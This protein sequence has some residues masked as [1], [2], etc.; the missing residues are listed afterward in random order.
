MDAAATASASLFSVRGK[1]VLVTGGSRGIGL[2]IARRMVAHGADVLLSSRDAAACEAAARDVTAESST[3]SGSGTCRFVSSNVS[4]REGCRALAQHA[5]DV[6]RGRLDVLVNNAG[7]SWGEEPFSDGPES[8]RANWG[9]DKVLDLNVKGV[10]Y[11]TRE[12]VPL[13][14]RRHDEGNAFVD[15][16]G[17]IVNVGSVAGMIPME[18]PTHAYDVSKAAVHHLTKKLA[19]DLAK[20]NITVNAVAPGFV[21]T[22]MSEGLSVWIDK[23]EQET[24]A[25]NDNNDDIDDGEAETENSLRARIPLGR[26]GTEEDMAGACIYFSSR[27]GA[28]CTGVVLN[29]DGGTAGCLQ[30]PLSSNL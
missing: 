17:R 28:W 29:V 16:P 13:L 3:M 25:G 15:D 6:F 22:R 20:R 26:M 4:S 21:E 24:K 11:L 8:G 5:R 7:C 1:K 14:E 30:L 2:M 12:C 19:A 27:A 10:F 9:W 18:S 23:K